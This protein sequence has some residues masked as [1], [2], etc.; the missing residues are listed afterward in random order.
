MTSPYLDR[1][2]RELR[3]A[4]SDRG[5]APEDIGMPPGSPESDGPSPGPRAGKGAGWR[6]LTLAFALLAV[7]GIGAAIA[8]GILMPPVETVYE[9]DPGTVSDIAPAAGPSGQVPENL[10]GIPPEEALKPVE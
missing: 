4:L 8:A 3:K 1:P 7:G 2:R 10:R 9:P 6:R 5:M